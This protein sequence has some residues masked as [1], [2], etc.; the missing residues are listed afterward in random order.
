MFGLL[1]VH[2]CENVIQ[3]LNSALNTEPPPFSLWSA[4]SGW[5]PQDDCVVG[6]LA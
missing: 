3:S 2:R 4:I 5:W 1:A 6:M